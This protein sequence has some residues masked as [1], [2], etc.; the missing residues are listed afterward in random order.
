MKGYKYLY[1]LALAGVM[2]TACQDD[3]IVNPVL[4]PAEVGDAIIFGARAG[5][6]NAYPTRTEYSGVTYTH[7]NKVFERIDWIEG[8]KVQIT[9]PQADSAKFA[10][11]EVTEFTVGDENEG[12]TGKGSDYAYLKSLATTTADMLQWSSA[13]RHEFYAMYPSEAMFYT[14]NTTS[15][16]QGLR[17]DGSMV[18]GIVPY[19]QMSNAAPTQNPKD[20]S[21]YIFKPNMNYAYM[22]AK[23]VTSRLEAADGVGL[24][25]MPIVTAVEITV[26]AQDMPMEISEIQITSTKRISGSF[27]TNL[28][29]WNG[30]DYPEIEA[31]DEVPGGNL[32]QI[33]LSEVF[34]L[35]EKQSLTFTVFLLPGEAIP[36]LTIGFSATGAGYLRKT[37]GTVTDANGNV[38]H[39][40][41]GFPSSLKTKIKGLTFPKKPE[42]N[43]PDPSVI[44]A[45]KWMEQLNDTT[46]VGTLSLPG[47]GASFSY[48]LADTDIYHRA[49]T[50]TFDQQWAAGIRAFEASMNIKY[51]DSDFSEIADIA[52]EP[53]TCNGEDLT[54]SDGT[55]I[56]LDWVVQNLLEKLAENK[57][58]TAMLILTY[59]PIGNNPA[60]N[61][62]TFVE[63]IDQYVNK[64]DQS[65][66]IRF[67]PNLKLVDKN[68]NGVIDESNSA[69]GKLMIVIRPTQ[70]DEDDAT[71]RGNAL[72][73]DNLSNPNILAI[74]GCGTAKDKWGVR[75]YKISFETRT[76]KS[77]SWGGTTTYNYYSYQ[78]RVPSNISNNGISYSENQE[79]LL[80]QERLSQGSNTVEGFMNSSYIFATSNVN[81]SVTNNDRGNP[82]GVTRPGADGVLNF[83]YGTNAGYQCW[84]QEWARVI[85]QNMDITEGSWTDPSTDNNYSYPAVYWFESYNEKLSHVTRTFDMAISGQ[86]SDYVFI[87]SLCGYMATEGYPNSLVPSIN[88]AY[89]GDGGDIETLAN[90]LNPAFYKYVRSS[91]MANATGPA[92]IVLMDRVTNKRSMTLEAAEDGSYFL[93]GTIIANNFKGTGGVM[94]DDGTTDGDG[95]TGSGSGDGA[96]SGGTGGGTD[97]EEGFN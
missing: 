51:S 4:P 24:S 47:T 89:G 12:T 58:E 66:L 85:P 46:K 96:G 49:Q 9:C 2:A 87:N 5:F 74:D 95:N 41:A 62:V 83:E 68:E 19:A 10:H 30:T 7:N 61:P 15:V 55:D 70:L 37:L 21:N 65:K 22:V 80:N 71:V 88:Y 32:I 82:I 23:T 54:T 79:S 67:S 53:I 3:D 57:K 27:R 45:S 63:G 43:E 97:G 31:T 18:Y 90:R 59:Q 86:F 38:T 13:D 77:L 64:I 60:R 11:Y 73:S 17:M 48:G 76:V 56:T 33:S 44:D 36:D 81:S 29:D 26:Q 8:D 16:P 75:G 1:M 6:E 42:E 93:P 35:K 28:Y 91:G 14:E 78:N 92:G 94:P 69:R 39:A 25:F 20:Q 72:A 34:V 84:F 52:D 40:F 50:L